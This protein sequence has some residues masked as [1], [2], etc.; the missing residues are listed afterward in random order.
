MGDP[1]RRTPMTSVGG[2]QVFGGTYPTSIWKAFMDAELAGQGALAL[3]PPGPVC[4]RPGAAISDGG[5]G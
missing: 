4:D 1:A 3:P 5:R 2:I